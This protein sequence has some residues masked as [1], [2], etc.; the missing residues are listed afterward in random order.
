MEPLKGLVG[1]CCRKNRER[2]KVKERR[3]SSPQR[4]PAGKRARE[5][6]EEVKPAEGTKGKKKSKEKSKSLDSK[7]KV[8]PS[9][10]EKLKP[11]SKDDKKLKSG[12]DKAKEESK[13]ENAAK[14]PNPQEHRKKENKKISHKSDEVVGAGAGDKL[15]GGSRSSTKL[16]E[17]ASHK[18]VHKKEKEESFVDYWLQPD[19]VRK[20]QKGS[21]ER[22]KSPT[23]QPEPEAQQ[24]LGIELS[25]I[26]EPPLKPQPPPAQEVKPLQNSSK[27]KDVLKPREGSSKR[28]DGPKPPEESL[29]KKGGPKLPEGSTK[30][31][32]GPPQVQEHGPKPPSAK[33]SVTQSPKSRMKSVN[34][35]AGGKEIPTVSD[36]K[37]FLLLISTRREILDFF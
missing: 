31:K 19:G 23:K 15:K 7:E 6:R 35:P 24:G 33:L 22:A 27:K 13:K 26:N 29:K 16:K 28:K 2:E 36:A 34:L 8:K 18:K 4:R 14:S 1:N 21:K 20:K 17:D 3:T 11:S 10:K 9:S 25:V 12:E 5:S 30:K 37:T 32:E